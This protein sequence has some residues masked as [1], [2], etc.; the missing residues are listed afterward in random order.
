M[1]EL[2]PCPFCGG[3]PNVYAC[4]GAGMYYTKP[5]TV[6]VLWGRK[7]T[8]KMIECCKCGVRTKAYLTD[9]GVFKA[10]NRRVGK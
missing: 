1:A 9:R 5:G 10:W 4:D 8:H 2:K 7:L 6:D 3:K